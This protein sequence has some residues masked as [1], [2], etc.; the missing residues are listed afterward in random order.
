MFLFCG[1]FGQ[2]VAE[3]KQGHSINKSKMFM[4]PLNP[5]QIIAYLPSL[6]T[7]WFLRTLWSEGVFPPLLASSN[8]P[9]PISAAVICRQLFGAPDQEFRTR[10]GRGHSISPWCRGARNE[11]RWAAETEFFHCSTQQKQDSL[12]SYFGNNICGSSSLSQAG[13]QEDGIVAGNKKSLLL[14]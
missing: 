1:S 12:L 4:V 5:K 9:V 3:N 11:N 2:L 10:V 8:L 14:Q 13:E 7:N 6:Q